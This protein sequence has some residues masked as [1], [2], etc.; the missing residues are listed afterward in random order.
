MADLPKDYTSGSP[1]FLFELVAAQT[2]KLVA[3]DGWGLKD[4][5]SSRPSGRLRAFSTKTF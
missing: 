1:A 2:T 5:S 4:S 3:W